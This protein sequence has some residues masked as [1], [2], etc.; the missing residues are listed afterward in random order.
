MILHLAAA[1]GL[2]MSGGRT[3][4]AI[5]RVFVDSG[6][7]PVAA[8]RVVTIRWS[9]LPADARECELLLDVD[10]ARGRLR[11]T[12]ELDP[13]AGAYRWTVPNLSVRSARIVLRV[14]RSGHE[15]EIAPSAAFE[16]G[17]GG[18]APP[19]SI[20]PRRGELWLADASDGDCEPPEPGAQL[21][22]RPVT[23]RALPS[24]VFVA[25]PERSDVAV[26]EPTASATPRSRIAPAARPLV[27]GP[28][29]AVS[30]PRRI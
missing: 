24:Y 30:F 27:A 20:F 29:F 9:G 15:I 6:Q 4:P 19:P 22:E 16:I 3:A 26:V 7:G 14:N 12:D 17:E 21:A 28:V 11:I 25:L 13:L 2:W 5:P 18:V 10:G 1:I 23:I 8:E